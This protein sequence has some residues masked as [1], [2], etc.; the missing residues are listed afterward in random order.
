MMFTRLPRA[1]VA[2]EALLE[3]KGCWWSHALSCF[4]DRLS[5]R[6]WERYGTCARLRNTTPLREAVFGAPSRTE[7]P[8]LRTERKASWPMPVSVEQVGS[9]RRPNPE[10]TA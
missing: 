4:E 3:V 8:T 1:S 2:R 9:S 6:M 10:R 5:P 7:R